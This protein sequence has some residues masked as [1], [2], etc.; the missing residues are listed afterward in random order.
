MSDIRTRPATQEYRE[1]FDAI[2]GSQSCSAELERVYAEA[3]M[4]Y[5]TSGMVSLDTLTGIL[6]LGGSIESYT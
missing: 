2:F 4:E 1:N 3:D 5:E 6:N